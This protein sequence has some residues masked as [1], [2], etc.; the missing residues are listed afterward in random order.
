MG[1]TMNQKRIGSGVMASEAHELQ[2]AG[3]E[4]YWFDGGWQHS[5]ACPLCSCLA[6]TGKPYDD[7]TEAQRRQVAGMFSQPVAGDVRRFTYE[8][9]N[10]G[11]VLSRRKIGE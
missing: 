5:K 3:H 2:D 10:Q 11:N 8:I 6:S 9:S 7:L 4:V 1:D